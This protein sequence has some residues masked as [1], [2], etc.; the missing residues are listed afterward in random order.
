MDCKSRKRLVH[1]YEV[2][3]VKQKFWYGWLI[4]AINLVIVYLGFVCNT[5]SLF[6][7]WSNKHCGM[8]GQ[9]GL[10]IWLLYIWALYVIRTVYL[11]VK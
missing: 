5:Y 7:C 9:S 2:T 11:D 4:R 3:L 8:D 10:L 6:G 1:I